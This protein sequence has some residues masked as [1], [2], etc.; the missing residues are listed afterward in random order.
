MVSELLTYEY[1]TLLDCSDL[2]TKKDFLSILFPFYKNFAYI[3]CNKKTQKIRYFILCSVY[4]VTK[5]IYLN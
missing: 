2:T 4:K 5:E 1:Q 3:I